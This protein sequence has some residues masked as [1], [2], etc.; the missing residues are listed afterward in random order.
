[1]TRHGGGGFS[2]GGSTFSGHGRS[3]GGSFGPPSHHHP[4]P[5]PSFYPPPPHHRR[6]PP[7]IYPVTYYGPPAIF[8]SSVP[9]VGAAGYQMPPPEVIVRVDR[10]T[11]LLNQ[12]KAWFAFIM[13]ALLIV[14]VW[15]YVGPYGSSVIE[16]G[17]H[18]SRLVTA[19]PYFAESIKFKN[20]Y[21]TDG[22]QIYVF[23]YKPPLNQ[24]S[25]WQDSQNA[26]FS[27]GHVEFY[28]W[29][30]KGSTVTVNCN[31]DVRNKLESVYLAMLP[32]KQDDLDAYYLKPSAVAK[33]LHGDD[34][35]HYEVYAD[36]DY[37][38]S[39]VTYNPQNVTVELNFYFHTR[40]YST[41]SSIEHGSL[42]TDSKINLS[43]LHSR[44]G[45]LQGPG[46][47]KEGN[48]DIWEI[49]VSYGIRWTA[50]LLIYGLVTLVYLVTKSMIMASIREID[51]TLPEYAP[52]VQPQETQAP[53]PSSV[54]AAAPTPPTAPLFPELVPKEGQTDLN[55]KV[56][57]DDISEDKLCSV[58]LDAR[59][60]SFFVPC[61]HRATC[62][63][64]GLRISKANPANCPICR[65]PIGE[66]KKIYD[67]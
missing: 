12:S 59:K 38:F 14:T 17:V 21:G 26:T 67:A 61:G 3:G 15:M 39:L 24:D 23:D 5:P 19:R 41:A 8:Y 52:L 36:A 35:L 10:R 33:P 65:Q 40:E 62:Y 45:L 51:P 44:Y 63:A 34:V 50:I 28:Y 9:R 11:K 20:L 37:A 29:M 22:P 4:P 48:V 6:P 7:P 66:I 55:E 18:D 57:E 32:N 16:L 58:C 13:V 49:E 47:D 60:D 43:F 31:L 56:T 25:S 2:G 46:S 54:P 53:A 42:K 64:C 27:F 1:M 30:N